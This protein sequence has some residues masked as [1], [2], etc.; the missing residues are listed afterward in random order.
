M[1]RIPTIL[2][3]S[4]VAAPIPILWYIDYRLQDFRR[5]PSDPLWGFRGLRPD[6]YTDE[7]QDWLRRSWLVLV[8]LIPWWVLVALV[9]GKGQ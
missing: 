4:L 8:L 1:L 9:L 2:F 3:V 5:D 6:Q 7:G